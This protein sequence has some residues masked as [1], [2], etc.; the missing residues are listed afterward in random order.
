[1]GIPEKTPSQLDAP[2]ATE[3]TFE[4]ATMKTILLLLC[5]V[6]ADSRSLVNRAVPFQDSISA[7]VKKLQDKGYNFVS[8]EQS[9]K[10]DDRVESLTNLIDREMPFEAKKLVGKPVSHLQDTFDVQDSMKNYEHQ[11]QNQQ[12]LKTP[13]KFDALSPLTKP[14][15]RLNALKPQDKPERLDVSK[16]LNKIEMLDAEE[17]LNKLHEK[18][19]APEPLSKLDKNF[20]APETLNNFNEKLDAPRPLNK[21]EKFDARKPLNKAEKFD[22][23][24]LLNKA[25]RFDSSKPLNKAEKFDS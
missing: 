18:L 11:I 9:E 25:E 16:P 6:F 14:E 13:N 7:N 15:K 5:V 23:S 22:V 24:K 1:M 4:L 12:S 3:H 21:A 17:P 10:F 20:D 8:K 19:D 2:T